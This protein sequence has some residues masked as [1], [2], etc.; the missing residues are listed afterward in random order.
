MGSLGSPWESISAANIDHM[1]WETFQHRRK[2]GNTWVS[3]PSS[4]LRSAAFKEQHSGVSNPHELRSSRTSWHRVTHKRSGSNQ[5]TFSAQRDVRNH[6]VRIEPS[7]GIRTFGV[8]TDC[9]DSTATSAPG[10]EFEAVTQ[11]DESETLT[12]NGAT[13]VKFGSQG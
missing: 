4:N 7:T 8:L 10:R 5:G 9:A 3:S 2:Q 1:R 13:L 6:K 11:R 12:L